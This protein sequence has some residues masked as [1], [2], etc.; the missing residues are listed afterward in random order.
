M[1]FVRRLGHSWFG[2]GLIIFVAVLILVNFATVAM[3]QEGG[4]DKF[5]ART[6]RGSIGS[7][8]ATA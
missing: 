8:T 2:R 5:G 6:N 1:S 3:A 7:S 4:G